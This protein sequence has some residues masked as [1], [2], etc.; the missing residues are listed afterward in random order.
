M[1]HFWIFLFFLI[2]PLT[3]FPNFLT[4]QAGMIV[5]KEGFYSFS[6]FD[7]PFLTLE[8]NTLLPLTSNISEKKTKTIKAI[9]TGYSSSVWETDEDPF[10]TAFGTFVREG[11][12]AN[13]FLPLGTKIKIPDIFGDKIFVVE[14]RMH[15]RKLPNHFDIWF[16]SYLEALQFGVKEATVEILEE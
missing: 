14:D 11:V 8:N 3:F 1:K 10:I 9:L 7:L 13:N 5:A 15:W 6:D 16:P 4:S 2:F 12:V